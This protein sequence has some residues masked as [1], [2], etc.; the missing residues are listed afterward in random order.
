MEPSLL[1]HFELGGFPITLLSF[2]SPYECAS[3]LN[4][5]VPEH[6]GFSP[7]EVSPVIFPFFP[8]GKKGFPFREVS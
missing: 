6:G 3:A 8:I 5:L 4:T 7:R 2:G 1:S